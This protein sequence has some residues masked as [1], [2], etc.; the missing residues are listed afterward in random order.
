VLEENDGVVAADGLNN[1][2]AQHSQ[3]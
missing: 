2:T 3:R 1:T